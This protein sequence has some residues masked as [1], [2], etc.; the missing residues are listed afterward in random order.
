LADKGLLPFSGETV[1]LFFTRM[2]EQGFPVV[3]HS[4]LYKRLYRP[5]YRVVAKQFLEEK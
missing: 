2:E 1:R 3:H 4:K 5:A